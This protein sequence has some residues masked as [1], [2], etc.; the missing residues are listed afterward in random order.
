MPRLA[1]D[2]S[3]DFI[4]EAIKEILTGHSLFR[5]VPP[6]T[7]VTISSDINTDSENWGLMF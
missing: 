5:E 2:T 6:I 3:N 7:P 4:S 1:A